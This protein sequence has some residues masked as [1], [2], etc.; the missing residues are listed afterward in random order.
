VTV[1]LSKSEGGKQARLTATSPI[2]RGDDHTVSSIH[3]I[4]PKAARCAVK[5][6]QL[7]IVESGRAAILGD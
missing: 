3:K 6:G 7:D 2:K 1:V 4:D 5:D